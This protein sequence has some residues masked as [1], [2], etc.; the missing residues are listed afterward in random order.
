MFLSA[1]FSKGFNRITAFLSIDFNSCSSK[2][3][4]LS[5][6]ALMHYPKT[7]AAVLPPCFVVKPDNICH[8]YAGLK[9]LLRYNYLN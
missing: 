7:V 2:N 6:V 5:K 3:D 4:I 8:F 1:F 9:F